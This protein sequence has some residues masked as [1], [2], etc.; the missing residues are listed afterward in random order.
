MSN[1]QLIGINMMAKMD[2]YMN[3]TD[4]NIEVYAAALGAVVFVWNSLTY[5]K[6]LACSPE[7][8]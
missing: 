7:T 1:D 6:T 2:E 3:V 5:E 8:L 4:K